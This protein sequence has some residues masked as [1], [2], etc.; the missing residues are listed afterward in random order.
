MSNIYAQYHT[1]MAADLSVRP[2]YIINLNSRL[3]GENTKY[4]AIELRYISI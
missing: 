3:L 2:N 1:K 4:Q